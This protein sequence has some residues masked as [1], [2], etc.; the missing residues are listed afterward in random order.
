LEDLIYYIRGQMSEMVENANVD[1]VC[2]LPENI[3][4]VFFGWKR[5]RNT[6]LLVKEA[7]NNAL[8]HANAKTITL[9]FIISN[10]LH[11]TIKDDGKGFDTTKNFTGNGLNNYKKRI[12][13]LNAQY[14]L[15]SEIDNGTTFS[16]QLPIEF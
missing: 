1:F 16:F 8:K 9:D 2:H 13:D 4:S 11:I 7:I 14:E 12:T 15:Q 6:Y 5:N 10:S 3:P